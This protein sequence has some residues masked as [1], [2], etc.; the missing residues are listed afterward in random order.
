MPTFSGFISSSP[1]EGSISGERRFDRTDIQTGI[2]RFARKVQDCRHGPKTT[3]GFL[4]FSEKNA[5]TADSGPSQAKRGLAS[6]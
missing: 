5:K 3:T 1:A 6:D 2:E 4:C